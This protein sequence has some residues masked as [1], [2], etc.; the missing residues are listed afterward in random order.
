MLILISN[1]SI[2]LQPSF[3]LLPHDHIFIRHEAEDTWLIKKRGTAL[4]AGGFRAF[5]RSPGYTTAAHL[6][7]LETC[8]SACYQ[9]GVKASVMYHDDFFSMDNKF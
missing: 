9:C 8:L 4:A 2:L 1:S 7:R 5:K 6:D 3:T